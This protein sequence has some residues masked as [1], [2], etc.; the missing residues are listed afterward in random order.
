MNLE[1]HKEAQKK[2]NLTIGGINNTTNRLP[3]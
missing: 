2:G 3:F 1:I